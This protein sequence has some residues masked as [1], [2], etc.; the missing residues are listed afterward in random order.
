[1]KQKYNTT[2]YRRF[3]EWKMNLNIK[4]FWVLKIIEITKIKWGQI[5]NMN[6]K[7]KNG[8]QK[9]NYKKSRR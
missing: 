6:T 8:K 2:F 3:R 1:M 5:R 9:I 7:A 4:F